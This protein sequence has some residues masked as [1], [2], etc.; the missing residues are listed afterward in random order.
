MW[1]TVLVMAISVIFEPV[2]LGLA[3]LMLNRPRPMLQLLVF[4]CG[5]FTMG[6]S[7][8]LVT[9]FVLRATPLV[10]NPHFTVPNVQLAT[11]VI[12]LII[13]GLV[14]S[15]VSARFSRVP[16]DATTGG[17]AGVALLE[18]E[19]PTGLRKQWQRAR[20][21]LQGDSLLVAAVSGLMT[22]LPSANFLGA[23]AVILA[24]KA[25]P[26]AQVLAVLMFTVV[27]FTMAEIP[28]LSFLVAPRKTREFMARLHEWLRSRSRREVAILLAGVGCFMLALGISGL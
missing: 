17:D 28:L 27:A 10:G 6:L 15:N 21:F 8:G 22:A 13:A 23:I 12:V 2:R 19:P 25:A 7:V 11:G 14:A 16:A 5:G 24:S 26:D 1:T 9:L 4:L 3:V 20:D 18:G